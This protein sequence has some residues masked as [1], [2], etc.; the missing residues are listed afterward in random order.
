MKRRRCVPE[1]LASPCAAKGKRLDPASWTYSYSPLAKEL[2]RRIDPAKVRRVRRSHNERFRHAT[3][4]DQGEL[5]KGRGDNA[6][7][8]PTKR[9]ATESLPAFPGYCKHKS[10]A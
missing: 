1:R 5:W 9:I 6:D 3:T 2:L 8:D 10:S 7:Q 4:N